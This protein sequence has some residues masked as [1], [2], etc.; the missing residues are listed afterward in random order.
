MTLTIFSIQVNPRTYNVEVIT[1]CLSKTRDLEFSIVCPLY[2]SNDEV[3]A[4]IAIDGK[5]KIDITA[6]KSEIINNV[7]TFSQ[8]LYENVPELFKP[9][10]RLI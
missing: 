8:T 6:H 9:K 10:R 4:I 1:Y 5:Q 2:N 3:I 7:L